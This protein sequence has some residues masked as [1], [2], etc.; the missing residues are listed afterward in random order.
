[1]TKAFALCNVEI[2][3]EKISICVIFPLVNDNVELSILRIRQAHKT[4]NLCNFKI[5]INKIIQYL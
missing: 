5:F 4:L 1:M 2:W 3:K